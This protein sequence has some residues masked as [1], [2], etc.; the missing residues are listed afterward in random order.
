MKQS[1]FVLLLA[2]AVIP[3]CTTQSTHET[4]NC[5]LA[6]AIR[7]NESWWCK[8][9]LLRDSFGNPVLS[10][11]ECNTS[12]GECLEFAGQE[13]E[14]TEQPVAFCLLEVSR[15]TESLATVCLPSMADCREWEKLRVKYGNT[16]KESCRMRLPHQHVGWN[17][18]AETSP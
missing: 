17:T 16:L 10:H 3:A 15:I 14:C 13:M 5:T 18:T 11:N 1:I 7:P 8:A 9:K 4:P 12:K 2:L 6:E